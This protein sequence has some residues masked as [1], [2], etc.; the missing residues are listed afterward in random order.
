MERVEKWEMKTPPKDG[1]WHSAECC[2]FHTTH[3]K[4]RLIK[5]STGEVRV[6]RRA[7]GN[8]GQLLLGRLPQFSGA[9]ALGCLRNH[10]CL[11]LNLK[12]PF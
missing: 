7:T 5:S 8:Q 2:S 3:E 11:K 1:H 6:R 12:R 10:L 9:A 4:I